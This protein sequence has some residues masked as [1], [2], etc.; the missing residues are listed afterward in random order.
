MRAGVV[1]DLLRAELDIPILGVCMGMQALAARYGGSVQRAAV[2]VHGGMSSIEHVEHALF[3][4]IPS[5]ELRGGLE[6]GP[7]GRVAWPH[8]KA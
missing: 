4:D 1:G 3:K 7:G 5:G 6:G 8:V 2:P